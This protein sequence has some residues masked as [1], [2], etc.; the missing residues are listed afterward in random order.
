LLDGNHCDPFPGI[1]GEIKIKAKPC[2]ERGLRLKLEIRFAGFVTKSVFLN[3]FSGNRY[4]DDWKPDRRTH[5]LLRNA[6][7]ISLIAQHITFPPPKKST[8]KRDMRRLLFPLLAQESSTCRVIG[9][10]YNKH[11]SKISQN[12]AFHSQKRQKKCVKNTFLNVPVF[13]LCGIHFRSSLPL[14]SPGWSLPATRPCLKKQPARMTG[15]SHNGTIAFSSGIQNR[16]PPCPATALHAHLIIPSGTGAS[17]PSLPGIAS[18]T[19]GFSDDP[20]TNCSAW[21]TFSPQFW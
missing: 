18:A 4:Q 1:A 6:I 9:N 3:F 14:R 10:D 16:L 20:F 12:L 2:F 7:Q 5:N 13:F 8:K 11:F 17:P 21:L 15:R 19:G